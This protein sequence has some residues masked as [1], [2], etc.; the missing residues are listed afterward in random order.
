MNVVDVIPPDEDG[1]AL[2]NVPGVPKEIVYFT[3]S[4]TADFV[5]DRLD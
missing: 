1:F 5:Y 4:P 3:F 2:E